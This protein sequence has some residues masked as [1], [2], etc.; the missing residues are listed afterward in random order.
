MEEIL[1]GMEQR[2]HTFEQFTV[3]D[4]TP[5]ASPEHFNRI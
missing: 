1:C 2:F 4:F 5:E 3:S